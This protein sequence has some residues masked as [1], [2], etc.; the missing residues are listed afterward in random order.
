M[1]VR[2]SK[3]RIV[4]PRDVP[5]IPVISAT[6]VR[7][8]LVINI[9]FIFLPLSGNAPV[10]VEKSEHLLQAGCDHR[11]CSIGL[12]EILISHSQLLHLLS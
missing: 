8:H 3:S 11:M 6:D 12:F 4:T 10:L 1:K 7:Q 2:F 5:Q 9:R